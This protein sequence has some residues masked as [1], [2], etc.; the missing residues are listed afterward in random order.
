MYDLF[1]VKVTH[2]HA[3]VYILNCMEE[4]EC[5]SGVNRTTPESSEYGYCMCKDSRW[6]IQT[7]RCDKRN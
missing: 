3:Y 1:H 4:A 2:K 5:R 6:A 7:S